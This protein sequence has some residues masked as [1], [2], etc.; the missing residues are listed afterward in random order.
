[1]AEI[2]I[3]NMVC[4]R[5]I[6]AVKKIF[7]DSGIVPESVVLGEV[8]TYEVIDRASLQDIQKKLH[9]V[10]FEIIDD[11]KAR[12]IEKIRNLIIELVHHGREDAHLNYS[13]LITSALNKDYNYLS[14]LFSSVVGLTIEKYI[15]H[16]K[17]ERV[18]ELLVYDELN[19]SEI[20]FQLGYSSVAHLSS[21]FKKVTGLTPSR[22]KQLRD[23]QRKPLD[24]VM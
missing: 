16:Q 4:N 7:E 15:I 8:R 22:F 5:C 1:M 13:A 9:E 10:G 21:Q 18:K 23:P 11:N 20:S 19:L 2:Y 3:K 17:I 14:S 6:M 12:I 24:E